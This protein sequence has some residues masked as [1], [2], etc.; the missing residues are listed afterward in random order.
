MSLFQHTPK[1]HLLQHVRL[2]HAEHP[3]TLVPN[4]HS[5]H[6]TDHLQHQQPARQVLLGHGTKQVQEHVDERV[7]DPVEVRARLVRGNHAGLQQARLGVDP[8]P[9]QLWGK[10]LGQ[11]MARTGNEPEELREREKE[12]EELREEE[13]QQ[14]LGEVPEDAHLAVRGVG[15]SHRSEGHA[16]GVGE[17]VADEAARGEAVE[18]EERERGGDE[19]HDD[20]RGEHVVAHVV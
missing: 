11:T 8:T 9:Q 7:I 14:R 2:L 17:G 16:G 18:V 15:S 19:G 12:V 3:P 20:H 1:R 13:E 4:H 6:R 10:P 5:K